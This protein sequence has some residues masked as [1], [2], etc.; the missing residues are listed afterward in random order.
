MKKESSPITNRQKIWT[1]SRKQAYEMMHCITW[2]YGNTNKNT[3]AK[4]PED[5]EE[6]H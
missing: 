1:Y 3:N 6:G 4:P 2:C 5:N